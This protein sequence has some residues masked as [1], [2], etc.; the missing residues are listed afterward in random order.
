[1]NFLRRRDL[2]FISKRLRLNH[3]HPHPHPCP[4]PHPHPR[5]H[6]H[7]V[8]SV[9]IQATYDKQPQHTFI[10][11]QRYYTN[12]KASSFENTKYVCWKCGQLADPASPTCTKSTP[13]KPSSSSSSSQSQSHSNS[14]SLPGL[15]NRGE[16]LGSKIAGPCGAV[17]PVHEWLT[18]F[19]VFDLSPPELPLTRTDAKASS[20]SSHNN[21]TT[22]GR[23]LVLLREGQGSE[24]GKKGIATWGFDLDVVA[25]KRR[26]LKLQSQ[27]HPDAHSLKSEV[28]L[29][30][31]CFVSV[32]NLVLILI[33]IIYV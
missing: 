18:F 19:D 29:L 33:L 7:L 27:V 17:Q 10:K 21:E 8:S 4:H 26:F 2:L 3:P 1:M 28:R 12:V 24:R 25:L 9:F 16:S 5:P 11:N 31:L 20:P 32:L 6:P 15:K 22:S 30:T 23:V 13:S 14:N